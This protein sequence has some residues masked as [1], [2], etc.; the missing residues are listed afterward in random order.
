M[1]N[2]LSKLSSALRKRGLHESADKVSALIK[3]SLFRKKASNFLGITGPN[4]IAMYNLAREGYQLKLQYYPCDYAQTIDVSVQEY[5]AT[6]DILRAVSRCCQNVHKAKGIV[7]TV[8]IKLDAH[9]FIFGWDNNSLNACAGPAT[10]PGA[11][12]KAIL[13]P[14]VTDAIE[15]FIIHYTRFPSTHPGVVLQAS[16]L[17]NLFVLLGGSLS[18]DHETALKGLMDRSTSAEPPPSAEAPEESSSKGGGG[19][20]S[21]CYEQTDDGPIEVPCPE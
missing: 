18:N 14:A 21:M 10:D 8:V 6:T 7:G 17:A 9:S 12:S 4:Q 13:L 11:D 1:N 20:K 15:Q 5:E 19:G 16:L 3:T 2:K